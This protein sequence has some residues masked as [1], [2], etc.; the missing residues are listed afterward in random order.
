MEGLL[1]LLQNYRKQQS[2]FTFAFTS[3]EFWPYGDRFPYRT[4]RSFRRVIE[5]GKSLL[6][7]MKKRNSHDKERKEFFE[8]IR[9]EG[10]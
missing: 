3:A 7:M 2:S 8:Q 4:P 10:R 9:W 1:S 5:N 6:F